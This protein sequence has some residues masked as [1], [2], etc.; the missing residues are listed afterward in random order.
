METIA[1][2][3]PKRGTDICV[4]VTDDN[5][6]GLAKVT[7][8]VMS[9][10]DGRPV[11]FVRTDVAPNRLFNWHELVRRRPELI[12]RCGTLRAVAA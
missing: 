4:W 2:L 6:P 7:E 5:L 9:R 8:V 10:S 1:Y 11:P 3:A 12:A